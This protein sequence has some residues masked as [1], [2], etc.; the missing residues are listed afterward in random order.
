MI[1][2][3]HFFTVTKTSNSLYL[4]QYS[5]TCRWR[6][7]Q[8][9][10]EAFLVSV[11]EER[12]LRR[13]RQVAELHPRTARARLEVVASLWGDSRPRRAWSRTGRSGCSGSP[14]SPSSTLRRRG[15]R[16]RTGAKWKR[17]W[18][19]NKI[20]NHSYYLYHRLQLRNKL[21]FQAANTN[22]ICLYNA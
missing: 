6:Q 5:G 19:I 18:K 16:R 22:E 9:V 4:P 2:N 12:F 21:S 17:V 11:G 1:S 15:T 14:P 7:P 20:Q 13:I 8:L 10:L 3:W